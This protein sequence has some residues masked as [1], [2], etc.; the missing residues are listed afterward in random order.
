MEWGPGGWCWAADSCR[1]P[2]AVPDLLARS[3]GVVAGSRGAAATGVASSGHSS[4]S[5]E[6]LDNLLACSIV[7]LAGLM[8][9]GALGPAV[10]SFGVDG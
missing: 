4:S 5:L 6:E 3:G 2:R 8:V 1:C 9:C 7:E 10:D